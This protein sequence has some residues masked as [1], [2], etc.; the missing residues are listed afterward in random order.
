MDQERG[1]SVIELLIVVGILLVIAAI[2]IPKY[3]EAKVSADEAAAV[4]T[5]RTLATAEVA[6]LNAYPTVGYAVT[7]S[8]LGTGGNVPCSPSSSTAC[9][10]DDSLANAGISPGKQGYVFAATGTSGT[11]L[12]TAV[13]VSTFGAPKSFCEVADNIPRVNP[14]GTPITSIN[15]CLSFQSLR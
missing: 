5:I 14:A 11:Y 6:Y 2:A 1:F 7:L 13:P 15:S 3:L 8:E 9:M 12:V 10:I 4:S